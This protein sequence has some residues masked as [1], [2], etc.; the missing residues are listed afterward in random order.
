MIDVRDYARTCRAAPDEDTAVDVLYDFMR[1]YELD[2]AEERRNEGI[3]SLIT[4]IRRV[5]L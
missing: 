1:E 4:D 2:R 3:I 5:R